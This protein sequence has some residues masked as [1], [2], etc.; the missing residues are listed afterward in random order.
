MMMK[1][2]GLTALCLALSTAPLFGCGSSGNT[3]LP[4]LDASNDAVAETDD[5][6]GADGATSSDGGGGTDGSQSDDAGVPS[7]G[8]ADGGAAAP[9][10]GVL[11][12]TITTTAPFN[13][14]Q[15]AA[16]AVFGPAADYT[17]PGATCSGT[18]A[19]DCC[20]VAPPAPSDAGTDAGAPAP[21]LAGI[22]TWNASGDA[23]T[24]ATMTPSNGSYAAVT[25]PPT[26]GLTWNAGDALGVAATG[27]TV[28]PFSGTLKTGALL[29][30]V[31]PSLG[32]FHVINRGQNYQLSWTK[33]ASAGQN[34]TLVLSATKGTTAEGTITC[35]VPDSQAQVT[36]E[37]TLLGHFSAG[38]NAA[39]TLSRTLHSS[40]SADNA[41]IHLVGSS[42]QSGTATLQ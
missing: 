29:A 40:A 3:P 22:I 13:T 34:V 1:K 14:N 7:E 19:G 20:F 16:V 17:A 33:D 35:V 12:A 23:G 27:D 37:S 38:D 24:L 8:G 36:V 11:S 28:H 18:K 15:Y 21:V 25:N 2:S 41:S 4:Q 39:L 9:Y 5:G 26:S 6:G 32:G 10:Y 31:T 42:M 30:G